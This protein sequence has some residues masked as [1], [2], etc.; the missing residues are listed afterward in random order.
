[1][2]LALIGLSHKTCPVEVRERLAFTAPG[3]LERALD[4]LKGALAPSGSESVLLSTCNRTE[5]YIATPDTLELSTDELITLLVEARG[6]DAEHHLPPYLEERRGSHRVTEH[7]FRVASGLESM[8]LGE[9]DIVR[10]VKEAYGQASDHALCGPVLNPL[11]HESLRVAKRARTEFEMQKGAFSVGHAAAQLA[12]NIFGSLQGHTVLL[13][14]AGAMSETTARHL[15]ASGASSVLVANRTF[16]RAARLAEAL[17]GRAIQYDEFASHLARTDIVISS[18]AAPHIVVT[19]PMVEA[20]LRER[21]H[22]PLFLI[23][24]AVPRD[25]EASVGDLP[26]V[27]LYNIDDLQAVVDSDIS[28]RRRRAA[29]AETLVHEEAVAFAARQ[30]ATQTVGPLVSS[31]RAKQHAIVDDELGRLRRRLSHLPDADWAAIEAFARSV[32]NKTLHDPTLKVKEYAAPAPG[33]EAEAEAKIATVR[34][35]FGLDS[36]A[37]TA[38]SRGEKEGDT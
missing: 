31:L 38:A 6:D 15:A 13:L 28:E 18:T 22:R 35:I 23:D 36:S 32:E 25:I 30:R 3:A 37:V 27:F 7:L 5:L 9:N 8:V 14:G 16:D 1:M 33:Q 34:E 11:F 10:Q 2:P 29:R 17:N 12:Q 4:Y 21:R 19:R 20:V 26:D 24:I